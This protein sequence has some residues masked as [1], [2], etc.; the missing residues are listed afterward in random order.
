MVACANFGN[1]C[2]PDEAGLDTRKVVI[3]VGTLSCTGANVGLSDKDSHVKHGGLILEVSAVLVPKEVYTPE[4][5]GPY[6]PKTLA[7][8]YD[9]TITAEMH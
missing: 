6:D 5:A 4:D 8:Y 2:K 9:A 1:T 7:K 3:D